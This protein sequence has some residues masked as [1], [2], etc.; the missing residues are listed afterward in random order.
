MSRREDNSQQLKIST[1]NDVQKCG[2]TDATCASSQQVGVCNRGQAWVFGN[3]IPT[4]S[5][6]TFARTIALLAYAA[7]D[8]LVKKRGEY[9]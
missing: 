5:P 9:M 8:E 7:V 1:S 3:E 6:K 4:L 2:T